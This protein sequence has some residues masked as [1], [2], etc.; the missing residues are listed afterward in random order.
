MHANV[1]RAQS[2]QQGLRAPSV[3]RDRIETTYADLLDQPKAGVSARRSVP[4]MVQAVPSEELVTARRA[5]L[6]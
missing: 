3:V 2:T 6:L 1:I 5:S 4:I